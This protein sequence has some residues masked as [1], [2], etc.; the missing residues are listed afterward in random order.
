MRAV[1]VFRMSLVAKATPT[2]VPVPEIANEPV[3][4]MI[5]DLSDALTIIS[6]PAMTWDLVPPKLRISARISLRIKLTA[7]EPATD[8]ALV[9]PVPPTAI[10]TRSE[11]ASAITFTEPSVVLIVE[12]SI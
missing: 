6:P 9:E 3:I 5:R 8:V 12:P 2:P 4:P 10:P 11:G 7:S 1:V